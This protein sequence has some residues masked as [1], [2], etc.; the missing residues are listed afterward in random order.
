MGGMRGAV[1]RGSLGAREGR[2][3]AAQ[4]QVGTLQAAEIHAKALRW[5]RAGEDL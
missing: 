4:T 1:R 3:E 2:L 5:H